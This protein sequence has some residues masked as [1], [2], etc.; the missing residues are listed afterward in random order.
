MFSAIW[1]WI[2]GLFGGKGTTQIGSRNQSVSGVTT[3]NVAGPVAVGSGNVINYYDTSTIPRNASEPDLSSDEKELL[4]KMEKSQEGTL[5][6]VQTD[7]GL[8]MLVDCQEVFHIL[9]TAGR[10][11]WHAAFEHLLELELIKD[12]R[13]NGE[14]YHLSSA[15]RSIAESIRKPDSGE[16][17]KNLERAP[18]LENSYF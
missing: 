1:E 5:M 9:D 3:G 8:M 10:M 2:K 6:L 7:M 13:G 15:G 14:I 16:D 11:R 12:L 17:Q 4:A 18:L